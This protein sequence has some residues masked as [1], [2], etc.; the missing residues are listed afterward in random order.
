[1]KLF[2]AVRARACAFTGQ[3]LREEEMRTPLQIQCEFL[4]GLVYA[5]LCSQARI[6]SKNNVWSIDVLAGNPDYVLE[7]CIPGYCIAP[8]ID[9][10]ILA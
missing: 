5:L 7:R 3:P 2:S 8:L 6:S 9:M 4:R 1:M 10:Q